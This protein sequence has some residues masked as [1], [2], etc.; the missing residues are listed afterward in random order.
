MMTIEHKY[1][2][3][4]DYVDREF[5]RNLKDCGIAPNVTE[6]IQKYIKDRIYIETVNQHIKGLK[7]LGELVL[8]DE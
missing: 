5:K 7:D 3:V 8:N 2:E 4:S 6:Y 1:E